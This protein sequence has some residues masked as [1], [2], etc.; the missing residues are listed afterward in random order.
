MLITIQIALLNTK[1]INVLK[2][3]YVFVILISRLLNLFNVLHVSQGYNQ[4]KLN[5]VFKS[6]IKIFKE[7]SKEH[8]ALPMLA[9]SVS[10]TSLLK[11]VKAH[12]EPGQKILILI[13][14]SVTQLVRETVQ[15]HKSLLCF[16]TQRKGVNEYFDKYLVL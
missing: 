12:Y 2:G 4:I 10:S 13:T 11:K 14:R 15:T 5:P 6:S 8:A 3:L 7:N 16:H 1:Y 9:S